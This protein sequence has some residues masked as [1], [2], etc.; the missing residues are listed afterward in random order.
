MELVRWLSIKVLTALTEFSF[1]LHI[2]WLETA[3]NS[4]S[5]ESNALF[6]V[7]ALTCVNTQACSNN[8][9]T[10][11]QSTNSSL[12]PQRHNPLSL[13]GSLQLTISGSEKPF[14]KE[15]ITALCI[16]G[17]AARGV[18]LPRDTVENRVKQAT[19]I[20]TQPIEWGPSS[21]SRPAEALRLGNKMGAHVPSGSDSV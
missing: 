1:Q 21:A 14:S 7:I 4:S 15:V 12:T 6:W 13:G 5:R 20:Q 2:G 9:H 19:H 10:Q 11:Q 3:C 18:E 17:A 8:N 16:S